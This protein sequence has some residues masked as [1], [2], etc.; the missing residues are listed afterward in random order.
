MA[1]LPAW[2]WLTLASIG[3][4]ATL[5]LLHTLATVVRNETHVHE[6]RQ[7]VTKLRRDQNRRMQ[8]AA[9]FKGAEADVD[10]IE[11]ISTPAGAESPQAAA[12]A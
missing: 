7:R 3:A 11:A 6:L 9:G 8:A 2:A 12:A 5:A 1:E 10:V 4:A